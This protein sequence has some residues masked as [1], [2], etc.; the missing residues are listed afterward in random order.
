MKKLIYLSVFI[1]LFTFCRKDPAVQIQNP[2]EVDNRVPLKF[3]FTGEWTYS[4]VNWYQIDSQGGMAEFRD[5]IRYFIEGDTLLDR[6]TLIT[7]GSQGFQDNFSALEQHQYYKLK[8]HEVSYNDQN[9]I[10]QLVNETDNVRGYVRYDSINE[11]LFIT[12][13]DDPNRPQLTVP[14]GSEALLIDFNLNINDTLK[15]GMWNGG[16]SNPYFVND[17]EEIN[18]SSYILKKYDI[19]SNPSYH[20]AYIVNG[21]GSLS[22]F[23]SNYGKLIHYK[24]DNFEYV[25]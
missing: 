11:K 9:G 12:Y 13:G 25:P 23:D 20:Y 17:V 6:T 5:T 18:N 1:S 8:Y 4:R 22:G 3:D 7:E 15:W 14:D 19:Y 2:N 10:F 24:S 16:I 21:I